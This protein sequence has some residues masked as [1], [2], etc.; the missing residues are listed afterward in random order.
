MDEQD[1]NPQQFVDT[2]MAYLQ[3]RRA[4][5]ALE[6]DQLSMEMEISAR[7]AAALQHPDTKALL[8]DLQKLADAET[9]KLKRSRMDGYELGRR[10]GQIWG[11]EVLLSTN[12][13]SEQEIADKR[14]RIEE[15]KRLV[16]E[17]DRLLS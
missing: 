8:E 4:E 15:L 13:L 2:Q 11:V 5:R 3:R 12:I 1:F 9:R 7:K 10:Q 16:I 17:D 6:M 14:T